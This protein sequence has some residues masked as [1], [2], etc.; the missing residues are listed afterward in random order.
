MSTF[1][2]ASLTETTPIITQLKTAL[3]K[4]VSQAIVAI[5]IDQKLKKVGDEPTKTVTFN[6]EN[7]QS[8]GFIFRKSGDV[9]RFLLNGKDR[10]I[11]GDLDPNY[12]PSFNSAITEIADIIRGN[13]NKFDKAKAREKVKIPQ[14]KK[15]KAAT[16]T[17]SIKQVTENISN[18]DQQLSE[19][20]DQLALMQRQYSEIQNRPK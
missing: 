10:P 13:Q 12:K 7:G 3:S 14:T 15:D 9:L 1:S 19:K 20:S 11:T 2:L 4:A 18:L 16:T 17:A 6:L 5:I 8:A